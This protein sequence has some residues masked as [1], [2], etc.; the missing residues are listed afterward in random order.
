MSS[1]TDGICITACIVSGQRASE[2]S[3]D[4]ETERAED[5]SACEDAAA[6]VHDQTMGRASERVRREETPSVQHPSGRARARDN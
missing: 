3:N 6:F 1:D 5:R 2:R 4:D